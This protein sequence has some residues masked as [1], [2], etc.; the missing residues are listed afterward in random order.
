MPPELAAHPA[1][2]VKLD[3]NLGSRGRDALQRAGFDVA[4]VAEQGLSASS[5]IT[6]A[7][8]C[9]AESRCLV[10]LDLD[11]ANPLR[12]PPSRYAGLVV[13]RLRA[14]A[15]LPTIDAACALFA[16]AATHR[17]VSGRLWIVEQDRVREYDPGERTQGA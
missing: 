2:R 14:R 8:V 16:D 4:T 17:S 1:V 6:L 3:E 9:R 5:D 12:F 11:F 15:T 10:T 13:L 7:E